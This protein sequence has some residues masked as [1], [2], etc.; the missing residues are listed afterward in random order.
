MLTRLKE[1]GAVAEHGDRQAGAVEPVVHRGDRRLGAVRL[2]EVERERVVDLE[3]EGY[4]F[5]A[6][7][8]SFDLL[9]RK[10]TG[11]YKPKFQRLHYRVNVETTAGQ[12]TIPF[13]SATAWI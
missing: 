1:K 8:A 2:A 3:N 11:A 9:V 4:Q 10:E 6:A 13:I 12:G 7:E 5:E